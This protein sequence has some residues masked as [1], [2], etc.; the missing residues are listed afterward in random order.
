M[1]SGL[2]QVS[3]ERGAL[4]DE[5]PS[6]LAPKQL[7]NDHYVFREVQGGKLPHRLTVRAETCRTALRPSIAPRTIEAE[8]TRLSNSEST[9]P[10]LAKTYRVTAG[11]MPA[12]EGESHGGGLVLACSVFLKGDT[13]A[14]FSWRI[15]ACHWTETA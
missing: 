8:K 14:V 12:D 10:V 4:N 9:G 2:P 3:N 7:A 15:T 13:Y 1:D 5:L 6:T 11:V